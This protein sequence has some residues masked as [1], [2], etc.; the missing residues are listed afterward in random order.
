M[1]TEKKH[2]LFRRRGTAVKREA[3]HQK[4]CCERQTSFYTCLYAWSKGIKWLIYHK[5]QQIR[6][7]YF[8]QH[9]NRT[10]NRCCM[11]LIY[12]CNTYRFA[13]YH[14]KLRFLRF[15]VRITYLYQIHSLP[16]SHSFHLMRLSNACRHTHACCHYDGSK[17]W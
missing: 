2:S 11:L 8:N 3:I 16:L 14:I 10:L 7:P 9:P 15:H 17:F 1:Y 12:L 6:A 5:K 13:K 4:K